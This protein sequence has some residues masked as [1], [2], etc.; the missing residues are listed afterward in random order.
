MFLLDIA[1]PRSPGD[2]TWRH[3]LFVAVLLM[4][5][6]IILVSLAYHV[7]IACF[8][9]FFMKLGSGLL[10]S[11]VRP[12]CW[13]DGDGRAPPRSQEPKRVVGVRR[14]KGYPPIRGTAPPGRKTATVGTPEPRNRKQWWESGEGRATP[15]PMNRCA[16]QHF[17]SGEKK[18]LCQYIHVHMLW[19]C[20]CSVGIV[21][22][23][24]VSPCVGFSSCL[25]PSWA[26]PRGLTGL[27][28]LLLLKSPYTNLGPCAEV[29]A[30]REPRSW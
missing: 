27:L 15:D 25:C 1:P 20:S 22:S 9:M 14:R 8:R 18:P 4:L 11:C 30:S 23:I 2:D 29:L 3:F 17:S 6:C 26:A 10:C 5:P 16:R 24:V 19:L 13:K 28:L 7:I 21:C 12:P